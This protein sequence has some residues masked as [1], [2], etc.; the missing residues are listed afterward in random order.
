MGIELSD[1]FVTLQPRDRWK[2]ATTQDEL[3]GHMQ[4]MVSTL[5]GMRAAFTQPIEMRVNEMIAGVRADLGVKL[6]GEDFDVLRAKAAEIE[7]ILKS[8]PG[9]ADVVA[10][11]ITGLPIMQII[12]DSE[13]TARHG[14]A[15][16]D[17]LAVVAALGTYEVGTLQDG[18][19]RFPIT[20]RIADRYR[21]DEAA[22]GRILVRS[23]GG[24]RIPLN[25]LARI[26]TIEGPSTVQREWGRRRV[27]VQANI[28]GRDIGS[29]V[30]E[31]RR[32]IDAGVELPAGYYVQFGG[33]FEHLEAAR[34][35]L[36][37][38][39]PVALALI[40]ILLYFTYGRVLDAVRVFTGVPFAAIGGVFALWLRDIPFS[41]PAGVGFVALSGVAVLGDMVLVSTFRTMLAA[42]VPPDQV[43]DAALRRLRPVLMTALVASLGFVPMALNTGIGA[44]VQ[45]PLATV[46]IGGLISSTLLTLF[47]LPVLYT[48]VGG[49]RRETAA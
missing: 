6:F 38:V 21:Q 8:I 46:V 10:E 30:A 44:E 13:A 49:R 28:R 39:V 20:I 22:I 37:I 5:P 15:K 19:R 32:A 47:V 24:E 48:L 2:R 33:Q 7:R 45:R 26:E 9:A 12:V 34:R 3:V 35:R 11:Q 4:A 23:P 42:G 27:I 41:V 31:A 14:I 29:F 17:V 1:V 18:E 40:F 43:R 36:M 16:A 25:R